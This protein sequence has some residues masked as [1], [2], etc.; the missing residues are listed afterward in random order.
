M[1]DL[2]TDLQ[3]LAR[4]VQ[5]I[6]YQRFCS[7]DGTMERLCIAE[8]GHYQPAVGWE[9]WMV[10]GTARRLTDM[11]R[12]CCCTMTASMYGISPLL[13]NEERLSLSNYASA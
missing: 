6:R 9:G 2:E 8:Y 12:S 10:H 3:A 5:R 1:D 13:T 7:G 4:H 11:P